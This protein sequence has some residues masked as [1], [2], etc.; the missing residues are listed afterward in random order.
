[1]EDISKFFNDDPWNFLGD[2]HFPSA[3]LLYQQDA[4]RRYWVSKS[5]ENEFMFFVTVE[6]SH[7]QKLPK[8]GNLR[9][10]IQVQDDKTRLIF[11]LEDEGLKDKFSTVIKDVAHQTIKLSGKNLIVGVIK[12]MQTW[13]AFLQPTREGLSE[14]ALIGFWGELYMFSEKFSESMGPEDALMAW[15]GPDD[16]KQ[17]FTFNNSAIEIKTSL[18]GNPSKLKINS[19]DQ[20]HKI[21]DSLYLI[22]VFINRASDTK[23]SSLDEL[24]HKCLEMFATNVQLLNKFKLKTSELYGKASSSQLDEKFV[25]LG[26]KIYFVDENFP[27]ITPLNV[28][29]VGIIEAEYKINISSIVDF[30]SRKSLSEIINE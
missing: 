11:I 25:Y 15:I 20:L 3:T 24:F 2:K 5:I 26:Q 29:H 4:K 16:K 13:S 22:N 17:D 9:S 8:L 1:M 27:T 28:N 6:G 30:E 18:S 14:S 21:T 23:G 19:L 10:E 12:T 7:K